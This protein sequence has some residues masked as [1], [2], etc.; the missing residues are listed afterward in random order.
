[1]NNSTIWTI[2]FGLS[3]TLLEN[4]YHRG[5]EVRLLKCWNYENNSSIFPCDSI[6]F[7]VPKLARAPAVIPYILKDI[8]GF[9]TYTPDVCAESTK[10]DRNSVNIEWL[11]CRIPL[12]GWKNAALWRLMWTWLSQLTPRLQ[13]TDDRSSSS[14]KKSRSKSKM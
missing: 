10:T 1:M 11:C 8:Q 13:N 5:I 4:W 7:F 12:S 9:C 14:K 2:Y 3:L 6:P